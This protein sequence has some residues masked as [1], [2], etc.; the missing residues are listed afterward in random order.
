[1]TEPLWLDVP[2][3]LD[4]HHEIIRQTGGAEGIRDLGLL[5]SALERPPNR[6]HY[7][8][9]T[10]LVE[11]AATYALAVSSNHPFVDGNKRAAFIA[12]GQF[13]MDNGLELDATNQDA[14]AVMLAVADGK[15][16]IPQL[17]Q[18]LRPRI[19]LV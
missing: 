8:G 19:V 1:M 15:I 14:T 7:E 3:L 6:W 17:A 9:L 13:L 12:L 16:D 10:D 4:L 18:W 11:L 2:L 5:E